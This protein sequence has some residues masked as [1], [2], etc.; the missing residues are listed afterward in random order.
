VTEDRRRWDIDERGVGVAD[1]SEL[2]P[3]I[4]ELAALARQD[5]WVAEDPEAH[6]LPHLVRAIEADGSPWRLIR[7]GVERG[8]F[9]LDLAW[10]GDGKR[11]LRADA[12]ALLGTI[13]EAAT[14]VCETSAGDSTEFSVVTGTPPATS[15]YATHGHTIRLRIAG[16]IAGDGA[17]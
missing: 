12:F 17:R 16:R 10:S 5:G 4:D 11:A 9:V 14:T 8:A 13:A 15:P 7:S 1:A 3:P 6:L 2:A